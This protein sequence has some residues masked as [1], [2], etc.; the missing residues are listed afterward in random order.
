MRIMYDSELYLSLEDLPNEEWRDI[1]DFEGLYQVSNYGRVKSYKRNGNFSTLIRKPRINKQ[2]YLYLNLHKNNTYKTCK[3]HRLVCETFIDC[4]EHK[5]WVNHKDGNKLNNMVD[6]LEWCTPSENATHA[7][8]N[9]L[10]KVWN[11]GKKYADTKLNKKVN[12]YDLKGNFIKCWDCIKEASDYYGVCSSSI[13][14]VCQ[15]T[16]KRCKGFVW[17]YCNK[18]E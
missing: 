12:Q 18:E 4:I 13:I 15:G 7:Y 5:S 9:N 6:N 17:R 3:I 8:N 2:G 11:K 1:K 14:R 10:R 16:K